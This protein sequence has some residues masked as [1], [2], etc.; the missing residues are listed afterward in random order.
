[1]PGGDPP[2]Q[3]GVNDANA[4]E[5]KTRSQRTQSASEVMYLPTR[6]IKTDPQGPPRGAEGKGAKRSA[7]LM[8]LD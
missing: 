6:Q 5:K 4:G 3:E 2:Q 7:T 8:G 1:M